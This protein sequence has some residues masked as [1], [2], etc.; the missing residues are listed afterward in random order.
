MPVWRWQFVIGA[1]R[2]SRCCAF[3]AA[4][5][6]VM[7]L[8]APSSG[9][10]GVT[11]P[12]LAIDDGRQWF[13]PLADGSANDAIR[14]GAMATAFNEAEAEPLLREIIKSK[15]RSDE[16]SQAHELLSRI[17]LR[18]GQYTRVID[19]LD[20]WAASFPNR[21]E[22]QKEK[23]DVELLRG[24]PDQRNDRRRVSTLRH[25]ADDWAV[26]VLING[27]PATYLFDTGAWISTMTESEARRLGLEI[28][29]G[30]GT[31]GDPSGKGVRVRTAVAKDVRL[32]AMLFQ[33]VSFAILPNQEPWNSMPPGRGGI[34]G[35][36]IWLGVQHV[37]WSNRGTWELGGRPTSMDRAPRNVVFSGNHLL[38]AAAVSGAR[39]FS[40]LDT[41]AVDTDLNENFSEQFPALIQS[42]TKATRQIT[43]LGGTA[44]VTSITVPEVPFLIGATRVVLRPAHVTL[45][46]T[47][48]IGGA[49]C[50]GNIGRDV[51]GRAG[52]FVLDLS[53]MVLRLQ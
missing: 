40:M 4:A 7:C 50:I 51:L 8:G 52:E 18:S 1:N 26:P 31:L 49:C 39:V 6:A 12:G 11:P 44:S 38:L 3:A 33:Q 5:L 34:L 25:D 9:Q 48:A 13:E 41:G 30:A 32:G 23:A 28:R 27:K 47:V 29:A 53:A 14:R 2:R 15:P 35:M 42:G 20:R 43:G 16:A 17:Y 36:P 45:Q 37:K 22:V 24:L 10:R 21:L 46:R 19:N